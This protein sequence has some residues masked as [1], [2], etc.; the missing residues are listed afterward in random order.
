MSKI[1]PFWEHWLEVL[2]KIYL[3]NDFQIGNNMLPQNIV[4]FGF[5]DLVQ[6]KHQYNGSIESFNNLRQPNVTILVPL[7]TWISDQYD[8]C[9]M[10]NGIL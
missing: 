3:E 5:L 7:S 6:P 4:S 1:L 8:R 9:V 2:I 10:K